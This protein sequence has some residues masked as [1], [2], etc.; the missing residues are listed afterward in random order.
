MQIKY[1]H[2]C[3]F[4]FLYALPH[5]RRS[6]IGKCTM[7]FCYENKISI[8]LTHKRWIF[9]F[10]THI[11]RFKICNMICCFLLWFTS[12]STG[13]LNWQSENLFCPKWDTHDLIFISV[14]E[15]HVCVCVSKVKHRLRQMNHDIHI[16]RSL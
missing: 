9:V 5:L 16:I 6:C 13:I 11:N 14:L 2:K 7:C 8:F 4:F 12:T 15:F 1:L 3:F 10:V